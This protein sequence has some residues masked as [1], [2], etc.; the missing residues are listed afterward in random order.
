MTVDD[1][2]TARQGPRICFVTD[3]YPPDIGGIACSAGRLVSH[4]VNAGYDM[5]VFVRSDIPPPATNGLGG[6]HPLHIYRVPSDPMRLRAAINFYHERVGF[7]LF[8]G[9]SI[10]SA[11]A[12]LSVAVRRGLPL[13][14]NIGDFSGQSYQNRESQVV[15]GHASWII[16]STMASLSRAHRIVDI[17]PKSSVIPIGI[18]S[19][20]VVRWFL[21][22]ADRGTVGM[23]GTLHAEENVKILA[24]AY[25]QLDRGVRRHLMIVGDCDPTATGYQDNRLRVEWLLRSLNIADECICSGHV[26]HSDVSVYLRRMHVFVLAPEHPDLSNSLLEAAAVG[27]PIVATEVEGIKNMFSHEINCLVVPPY[28]P[29]A[30]SRAIETIM[31]DDSLARHLGDGARKLAETMTA[32]A[33]QTEYCRV[34]ANLLDRQLLKSYC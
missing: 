29:R 30:L 5:H 17:A 33:E 27:V 26:P 10:P 34:Y 32:T 25:T 1:W 2:K 12:C 11:F 7:D 14:A 3:R 8:H 23:V 19:V 6:M 13:I 22:A 4:L 16:A 31:Q 9:F 24:Q 28:D 21:E 15:F 18:D 20:Q